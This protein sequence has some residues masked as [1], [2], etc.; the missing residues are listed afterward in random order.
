MKIKKTLSTIL[1]FAIVLGLVAGC[2]QAP[3]VTT[4]PTTTGTETTAAVAPA[5]SAGIDSLDALNAFLNT[6]ADL[7]EGS[8]AN[9]VA[10]IPIDHIDGPGNESQFYAFVKFKYVARDYIKY[11]ISYVSC[12]CRE[13]SVN[14]WQTAYLELSLPESKKVED[15]VIKTLSYDKDPSG[16]YMVGTWGDSNPIPNGTTYE[17]IKTE[18]IPY[19][20]GKTLG[21]IS[22]FSTIKDI[23]KADYSKGDGRSAYTVDS[24]SGATVSTNNILRLLLAAG[25]YHGTDEYFGGTGAAVTPPA[26]TPATTTTASAPAATTTP[27]A[28]VTPPATVG[29]ELPASRDTSKSFKA[30]KDAT[31]LTACTLDSYSFECSGVTAENLSQFLGREDVLYIDLRDF[32]DYVKKHFRNFEAVPFFAYI[33]NK[34]AA[35]NPDMIQLYGGTPTEPVPVYEE[36]DTLLNVFFPKD[37]TIFLMCQSGGRVKMLMDIMKARG[38]DMTKVYNVGGMAQYT[39]SEYKEHIT[40]TPELTIKSNYNFEGLTRIAP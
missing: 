17:Q 39:G 35:T 12:T 22:G 24:F 30:N 3:A 33:Y 31:E 28:V 2:Q 26:S 16:K 4:T 9:P 25:K 18:Y 38:W 13:A 23:D 34:D 1:S 29:A 5:P 32:E 37:K 40:D 7:G 15:S 8:K 19:Y 10:V 20:V 14:F 6:S 36:S 21:S 11:Q 27:A